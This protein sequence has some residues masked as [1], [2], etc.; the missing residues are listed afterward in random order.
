MIDSGRIRQ[1]GAELVQS[2]AWSLENDRCLNAYGNLM[3]VK[4]VL[5]QYVRDS[6]SIGVE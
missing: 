4:N 3:E 5:E 1:K 6:D 2:R